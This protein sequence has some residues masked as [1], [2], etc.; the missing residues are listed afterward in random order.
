MYVSSICWQISHSESESNHEVR[1]CVTTPALIYYGLYVST[2]S[3]HAVQIVVLIV[4]LSV[5]VVSQLSH[6]ETE[7]FEQK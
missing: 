3:H 2:V 5:D 1:V 6:S 7:F 4:H